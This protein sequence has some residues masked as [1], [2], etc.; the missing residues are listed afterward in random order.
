MPSLGW[1][2]TIRYSGTCFGMGCGG[3]DHKDKGGTLKRRPQFKDVDKE[4]REIIN[5]MSC[6]GE[7]LLI[8]RKVRM[9]MRRG[10]RHDRSPCNTQR[11][12]TYVACLESATLGAR[13]SF[14][15][16]YPNFRPVL[17]WS[18]LSISAPDRLV[19]WMICRL[20]GSESA[21]RATVSFSL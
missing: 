19:C 17:L 16:F 5:S 3:S 6:S 9:S 12:S 21:G 10:L 8:K 13:K 15:R 1:S 11:I 2:A 18:S 14:A 20:D 7:K 4:C